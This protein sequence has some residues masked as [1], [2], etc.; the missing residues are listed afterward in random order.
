MRARTPRSLVPLIAAWLLSCGGP[1]AAPGPRGGSSVPD[2]AVDDTAGNE[3]RMAEHV[4]NS[5]LLLNFWA[6]SCEP[7]RLEMPHLHR[8]QQSYRDNGLRILAV[9]M[10]GPES[11]AEVRSRVSRYDF[12]FTVLLDVDS[13]VTRLYNPRRAAPFN[14]LVDRSGTIAW[15][16][17]G[18]SAGDEV[19]LERRI[20]DALGLEATPS[21][22]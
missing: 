11:M 20:R 7:C 3:F 17:E 12:S 1:Q 14:V 22:S 2:F 13:E 4:G 18:Y 8:L 16:H 19:E 21:Q 10:D 9:S 5:V 15:T 6:T